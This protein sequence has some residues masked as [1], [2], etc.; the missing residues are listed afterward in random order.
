MLC[1]I[2]Q[3]NGTYE[4]A[5]IGTLVDA[6]G[7]SKHLD[8]T[9][10]SVTATNSWTS[11][12]SGG[13]YPMGWFVSVPEEDLSLNISTRVKNQELN[14]AAPI[15]LTYW[16]GAVHLEGMSKGKRITGVGYAEMTGYCERNK[17]SI[18]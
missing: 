13:T 10:F 5:S 9:Q 7:N 1:M 17:Q 18:F 4:P 15:G 6:Q 12:K 8:I 2:R 3:S 11:A 16:E 14:T